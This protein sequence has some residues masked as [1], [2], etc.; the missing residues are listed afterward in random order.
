MK[1]TPEVK[2]DRPRIGVYVCH[3]GLNIASTVDCAAVANYAAK[4]P[5]VV[6]ARENMYS[7]A[8]P[9]QNQIKND[10]RDLQLDRVVVAAC[11]VKMHGPTFMRCCADAGLNPYLVEM[12]NIR[13]HCS[14]VHMKDREG[15]TAKA[16]DQVKMAVA[17]ARY[18]KPLTDRSVPVTKAALV[19][20]GGIAGTRA[21]LDIADAGFP[22]YLAEKEPWLGGHTARLERVFDRMDRAACL[23]G[24]LAMQVAGHERI[25]VMTSTQVVEADG[26][27]GNFD[28]KLRREDRGVG[29]DCDGCGICAG[30][31][32]VDVPDEAQAGMAMRKAIYHPGDRAVPTAYCIDRVACNGCGSC[33]QACPRGA[34]ALDGESIE[35]RVKVGA[36][37]LATGARPA[38]PKAGNDHGYA[39][40]PGVVT[41][42]ELERLLDL[43][44]PSEGRLSWDGREVPQNIAF[45]QCVGSRDP[46]G[47]AWC[48]RVCCMNTVKQAL[49]IKSR[50]PD[51]SV[52]VYHADIRAY[53]KEHEDLYRLAREQG[54]SFLRAAVDQVDGTD[55][56]IVIHARDTVLRRVTEQSVDMVVL[57]VG[58]EPG[59]DTEALK[60]MFKVPL[61]GDGYF[62]EN[63]PKLRPL[64]TVIDGV[65]LAGTCQAPKDT[66]DSVSQ[67]DG[68]AAKAMGLLSK[69]HIQLDAIISTID[70]E[71]CSGCLICVKK[72]PFKTVVTDE[73]KVGEKVKKRARV[74]EAGC[75]GCG[76]C[77]ARCP[78][79]AIEAQGFTDEQVFAQI[80]AA[81]EEDAPDKILAITCHW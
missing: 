30:V 40:I 16:R 38:Q 55:D 18:L 19:V 23:I 21:A 78:K 14:W 7:C 34:I 45:I 65:M 12:A 71:A 41:S 64:E 5:D 10:I 35:G 61:S 60:D 74:V 80:E 50:Y 2:T 17:K 3:C 56:G 67:A 72:C 75:K 81:L 43:E 46:D 57:A 15:A 31:C 27:V 49:L 32:P 79:N 63:H 1:K 68:A 52:S 51:S 58:M 29:E 25:Q 53:K 42:V 4:L 59:A 11:S 20:G 33:V 13:E 70:Q 73:V 66:G 69:D 44:G 9:G 77:A 28:M 62:Q 24:P 36:V 37:I 47:N 48:S 6:V 8:D 26:Y 76:V 54:V 22:V 39:S